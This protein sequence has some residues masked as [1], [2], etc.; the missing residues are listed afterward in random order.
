MLSSPFSLVET[1]NLSLNTVINARVG[2]IL[3]MIKKQLDHE[4]VLSHIG[5]GVVLTGGGAHL[6][7]I[8]ELAKD[9]FGLPCV[10]GR[11]RNISGIATAT[12]G[13][14]Y[15]ACSGLVQYAFKTGTHGEDG[16][17]SL[18]KKLLK[19]RN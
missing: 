6:K 8:A 15:A 9:I 17:F 14:E 12:D 2:E 16:V 3:K 7:G 13:P 19:K 1:L 4:D 11:P 5:A 18:I 10:I